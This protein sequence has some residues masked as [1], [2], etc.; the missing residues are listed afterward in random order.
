M[1]GL[2]TSYQDEVPQPAAHWLH[3]SVRPQF[4][5][6]LVAA[7]DDVD[8]EL[9]ADEVFDLVQGAVLG[10]IFVPAIA[11]RGSGIDRTVDMVLR[12]LARAR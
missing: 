10:R 12:I 6:I 2:L 9:D 1:P 8:A 7:A 5:A 4:F 11:H 3:L